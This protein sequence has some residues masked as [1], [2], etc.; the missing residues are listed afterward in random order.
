MSGGDD[1]AHIAAVFGP[2]FGMRSAHEVI[3]DIR[4]SEHAYHLRPA[5]LGRPLAVCVVDALPK[6]PSRPYLRT[7]SNGAYTDDLL[8][9]QRI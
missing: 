2:A 7:R 3:D 9:L 8:Q 6:A 5:L 4:K 1:H